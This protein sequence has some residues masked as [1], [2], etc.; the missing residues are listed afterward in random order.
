M[1]DIRD[2]I[3]ITT[4]AVVTVPKG[5]VIKI[6][7][8]ADG[9]PPPKITWFRRHPGVSDDFLVSRTNKLRKY[10]PVFSTS[11]TKIMEDTT[12]SI[13][14]SKVLEAAEYMC[15]ATN[16]AGRDEGT[17]RINIGSE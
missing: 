17:T 1:T 10:Q 9:V 15:V 4:G 7:C 13:S 6:R 8:E 16:V 12:L 14:S 2:L 5:V 11:H 3:S